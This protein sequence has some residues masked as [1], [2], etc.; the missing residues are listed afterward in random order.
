MQNIKLQIQT[1]LYNND[2]DHVLR[3]AAALNEAVNY[4]Q[5]N[6]LISTAVLYYGDSSP[7]PLFSSDEIERLNSELKNVSVRYVFF[8]KNMGSAAGQNHLALGSDADFLF[9]TNPDIIPTK[10]IFLELCRPFEA[11]RD[12]G[13]A[14]CK[15]LPVEHPKDFD[16]VTGETS[17]ALGSC[18]FI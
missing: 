4:A 16:R 8:N 13:A 15:Q 9:I 12:A 1:I 17:W 10:N 5:I 7:E 6:G 11:R 14:E 3:S 2:I 18:T